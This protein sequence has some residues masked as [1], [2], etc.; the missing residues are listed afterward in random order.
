MDFMGNQLFTGIKIRL[1]IGVGYSY[2]GANVVFTLERAVLL[3]GKPKVIKA[4]NGPEFIVKNLIT[5]D[6]A[7]QQIMLL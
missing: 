6:L 4:D 5:Q 1:A 7:S 2:K 3:Y